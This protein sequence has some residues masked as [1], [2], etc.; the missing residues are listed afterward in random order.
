MSIR[1]RPVTSAPHPSPHTK[2]VGWWLLGSAE[3][4]HPGPAEVG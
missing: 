2:Y 4:D 1:P 3:D